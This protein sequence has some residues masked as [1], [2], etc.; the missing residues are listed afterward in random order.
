MF[1]REAPRHTGDHHYVPSPV[2]VLRPVE[3]VRQ[4]DLL[5]AS[6]AQ[7]HFSIASHAPA[8][9]W[10]IVTDSGSNCVNL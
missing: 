5:A 7:H 9:Q 3:I 1:C 10:R 2:D 6:L 8:A 4:A